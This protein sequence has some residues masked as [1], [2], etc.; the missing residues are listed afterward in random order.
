RTHRQSGAHDY[1][2]TYKLYLSKHADL[3]DVHTIN[4]VSLPEGVHV[5]GYLVTSLVAGLVG[6]RPPV[7][8]VHVASRRREVLER[9]RQLVTDGIAAVGAPGVVEAPVGP[10]APS[11]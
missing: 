8:P 1:T 2:H 10:S 9:H 5:V 4:W 7:V 3:Y 11:L 6:L